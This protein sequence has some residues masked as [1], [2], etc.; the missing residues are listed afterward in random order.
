[1]C[2]FFI[3]LPLCDVTTSLLGLDRQTQAHGGEQGDLPGAVRPAEPPD[4]GIWLPVGQFA[5]T[6]RPPLPIP[7]EEASWVDTFPLSCQG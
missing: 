3:V 4:L 2:C 5:L 1:M 6:P 7:G